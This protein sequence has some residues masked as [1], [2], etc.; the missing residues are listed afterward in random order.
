MIENRPGR[1]A[2]LLT[3]TVLETALQEEMTEHLMRARRHAQPGSGG[4]SNVRN[5]YP[6]KTVR[7]GLVSP[8][9]L[10]MV[11]RRRDRDAVLQDAPGAALVLIRRPQAGSRSSS[12]TG[13]AQSHAGAT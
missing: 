1:F 11:F 6:A 10:V 9:E 5:G 4:E 13:G 3:K 2:E 12:G 8:V 7:T